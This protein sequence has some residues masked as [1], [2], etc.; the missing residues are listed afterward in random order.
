MQQIITVCDKCG[1]EAITSNLL[2]RTKIVDLLGGFINS[3]T[4]VIDCEFCADCYAEIKNKSVELSKFFSS[5]TL[6]KIKRREQRV[7]KQE[8]AEKKVDISAP[9][10]Q[11]KKT[12]VVIESAK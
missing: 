5:F 9:E 1:Q 7:K 10:K 3:K 4:S 11:K 6:N 2:K 8:K 12:K